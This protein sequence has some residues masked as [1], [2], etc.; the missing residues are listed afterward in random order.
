MKGGF[1]YRAAYRGKVEGPSRTDF[2]AVLGRFLKGMSR[3]FR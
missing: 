2:V 1:F 3:L